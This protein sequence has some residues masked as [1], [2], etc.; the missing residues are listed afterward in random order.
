VVMW[1]FLSH[2]Q[3]VTIA[4]GWCGDGRVKTVFPDLRVNLGFL[5]CEVDF[6]WLIF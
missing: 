3:Q 1:R 5:P 2:L 6:I 4:L